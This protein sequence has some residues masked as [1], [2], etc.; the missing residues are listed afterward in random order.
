MGKAADETNILKKEEMK[1]KGKANAL[2]KDRIKDM[3]ASIA[4]MILMA[5]ATKPDQ[6]GKFCDSFKAFYNSKNQGYTD[7]ELHHQFDTKDLQNVGFAEETVLALWSG[8]LKRSNPT[9]PSNC[10]PFAFCELQPANMNQKGRLVICTMINQKGGLAQSAEEIKAEAKQEVLA[11]GDYNEMLFQL[12]AFVALIEILFGED[13]M[14]AHKLQLFVQQIKAHNIFYKG[15]AAL[16]KFFPMKVLW[17]VCTRFQLYL[18]N[19]TQAKDREEVNCSLINFST[20]HQ[21]IITMQF[22]VVLPLSFKAVDASS[23]KEPKGG[24]GLRAKSKKRKKEEE[25]EKRSK[26]SANNMVLNTQQCAEFKLKEDES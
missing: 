24:G 8:L 3:H 5:S 7:M 18:E 25:K 12:K 2:K 19:C 6:I 4:N 14:T 1:L 11:P 20:D 15:C 10:T 17:T 16:D 23:D 26:K 13:S 22:N 9:V 21:D